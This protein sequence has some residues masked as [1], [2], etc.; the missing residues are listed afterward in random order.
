MTGIWAADSKS[1]MLQGLL[2]QTQLH[3]H[4]FFNI[5]FFLFLHRDMLGSSLELA[6]VLLLKYVGISNV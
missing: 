5:F 2:I 6:S 4:G 1:S 3:I